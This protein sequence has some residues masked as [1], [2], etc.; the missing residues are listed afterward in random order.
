MSREVGETIKRVRRTRGL[1][2]EDLAEAARL[3]ISTVQKAEQGRTV[4]T[5]TL[6][7]I[8]RVLGVTTSELFVAGSPEPVRGDDGTRRKLM[9][10][11]AALMPPVGVDGVLTGTTHAVVELPS[12]RGS[13]LSVHDLYRADD[14]DAV[15]K[16]LPGV[17]RDAAVA[18]ASAETEEARNSA[19]RVR[20]LA[21]LVSGKYLTQVRQYDL[22][23]YA[24][25]EG[26]REA[27]SARDRSTVATGVVGLCWLL[28]R[29]DRFADCYTLAVQ[30]AEAMEPRISDTDVSRIGI[31]GELWMRAAAAAVRDNRPQEAKAARR[32]VARASAGLVTEDGEFPATWGGFGPITASIKA[33]EDYLIK[34][35]GRAEARAVLRKSESEV[36]HPE[37]RKRIGKPQGA[38]W[39][40]HL[41][42]VA[43]AHSLLGAHQNVMDTLTEVCADQ[44][45]WIKHQPMARRIMTD[46]LRTR[47]RTLSVEMRDM[48]T[49]LGISG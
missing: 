32:M 21:F 43:Q 38:N 15:A 42:D 1:S 46:V 26:I 11:R 29:Q 36:L 25:T 16:A 31:W 14:F 37:N 49:H 24:L 7:T 23:Y 9:P 2:Q 33:I 27:R 12:L 44:P 13:V 41:L 35:D 17:L 34:G 8:A 6:H 39:G 5:A 10:I 20:A 40:R 18:H 45:E 30:T 48:A 47:K 3:S 28:L 4:R 19:A 22:A